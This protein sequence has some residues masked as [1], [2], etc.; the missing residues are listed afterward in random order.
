MASGCLQPQHRPLV[1]ELIGPAG[2]GKTTLARALCR[3]NDIATGIE[4]S[5]SEHVPH[6]MRHSLL[7]LP[8]FI[9]AGV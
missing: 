2:S 8:A 7:L 3:R 9:R 4:L 5:R 6:V 1:V